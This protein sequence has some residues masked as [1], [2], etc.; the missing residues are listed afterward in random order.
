MATLKEHK[1]YVFHA[2]SSQVSLEIL[3]KTIIDSFSIDSLKS[4]WSE[5]LSNIKNVV[6][7]PFELG[8]PTSKDARVL[9][10]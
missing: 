8:R 9:L 2:L 7:T 6:E 1:T 10:N 4:D 3:A 5:G